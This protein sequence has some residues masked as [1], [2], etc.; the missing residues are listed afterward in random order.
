MYI[1]ALFIIVLL[2]LGIRCIF[3]EYNST[4]EGISMQSLVYIWI[5]VLTNLVLFG[6]II[7]K[8]ME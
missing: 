1:L 3:C 5:A 2:C 7:D 6:H 4:K 8:L